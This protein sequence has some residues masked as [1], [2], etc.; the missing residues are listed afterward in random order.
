MRRT[1]EEAEETRQKLLDAALVVFS[2]Q[3]YEA[4]RLEDI[5]DEAGVT[6]GAI[7]HHFGGK[8]ELYTA[9]LT[10]MW[11]RVVSVIEDAVAEGGT[12]V[13]ILRRTCVRKLAFMEE[14]AAFRAVNELS[15][16]KTSMT[17]ELENGMQMKRDG[18]RRG[19]T[20]IAENIQAG[21][22]EGSIRAD[23]NPMDAA[24]AFHSM[25]NG[26]M[27]MWLIDPTLFSLKERAEALTD[28]FLLGI[29][30]H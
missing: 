28:C 15:L 12:A 16:F 9:L 20:A 2:H 24:I 25:Q 26:L 27:A 10:V 18:M 29:A 1:K 4:T 23:V 13:D 21:I 22:D 6:R 11:E 8:P 5:A 3:G 30:A 7:Y 14:D 19:I 17:P